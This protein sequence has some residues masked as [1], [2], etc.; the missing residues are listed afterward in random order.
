MPRQKMDKIPFNIRLDRSISNRLNQ[1]CEES[2][3]TKT[4]AA[5]RALIMLMD[6]WERKKKKLE[7]D[8]S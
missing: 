4:L 8:D 5:E 1:Y 2:G 6:D 7:E 3:Q